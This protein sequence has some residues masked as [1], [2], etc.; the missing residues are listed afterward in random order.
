MK[1]ELQDYVWKHCLPQEFKEE[2]KKMYATP[3]KYFESNYSGACAA[4]NMLFGIHNLT[5]DAEGEEMLMVSRKRVQDEYAIISKEL[6]RRDTDAE[7]YIAWNYAKMTF[8]E[9]FGPKCLPYEKE[10]AENANCSNVDSPEANV[11]S[12]DGNVES[13][14]PEPAEP[15]ED[16]NPPKS[17][18]LESNR[19]TESNG[20]QPVTDSHDL[21]KPTS[22]CTDDYPSPGKGVAKM[23][24]I[25]S[26]VSVYIATKE[27][28][29]KFRQLLHN[30][31]FKWHVGTSLISETFWSSPKEK[32]KIYFLYP[33]KTVT[34]YGERTEDTLTFSEFKKQFFEEN[35]NLSQE[36]ADCDKEFYNILKNSFAKDRRL[37]IAVQFMSAMMSNPA[38][39]HQHLNAEEEDYILYGSLEFADALIA[40]SEKG[41]SE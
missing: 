24:P 25:E 38:I 18:P 19:T 33:D 29:E 7:D 26:K 4:F 11:D 16:L 9:L 35:V 2:V 5:S 31:G 1:K 30:N 13:L 36:T 34:Y 21:N 27:E 3:Y 6:F 23:K 8:E 39:F 14:Y 32:T 10:I 20:S 15:T 40:E 37:N 28:D 12:L 22:T 17:V 41:G